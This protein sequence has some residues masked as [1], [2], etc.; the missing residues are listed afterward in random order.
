M[1]LNFSR[2]EAEPGDKLNLTISADPQSIVNL[3]AVDQS[4]RILGTGNDITQTE[5]CIT[6][7][8]S[9]MYNLPRTSKTIFCKYLNNGSVY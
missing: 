4:V 8:S 5:V 9:Y 6:C 7:A 1:S 2:V 3:L